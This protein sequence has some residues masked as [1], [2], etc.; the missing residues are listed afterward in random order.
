MKY[1]KNNLDWQLVVSIKNWTDQ[2]KSIRQ[3]LGQTTA[4]FGSDTARSESC[5]NRRM[6]MLVNKEYRDEG[7]LAQETHK[8]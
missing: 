8:L 6:V 3:E 4:L 7:M 1:K 2:M 5:N